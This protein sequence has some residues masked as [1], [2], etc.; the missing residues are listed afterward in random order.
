MKK[1][2]Y[3]IFGWVSFLLLYAA[4]LGWYVRYWSQS[5]QTQLPTASVL[6]LEEVS[7]A[8]YQNLALD[9]FLFPEVKPLIEMAMEDDKVTMLELHYIYSS[10]EWWLSYE[11]PNPLVRKWVERKGEATKLYKRELREALKEAR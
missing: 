10:W 5:P 1:I 8:S 3:L 11:S 9:V 2:H 7:P 4:A 6:L